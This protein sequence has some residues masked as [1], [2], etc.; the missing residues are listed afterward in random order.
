MELLD[1]SC[2]DIGTQGAQALVAALASSNLKTL[3][4]GPKATRLD[5]RDTA[6]LATESEPEEELRVGRS[7]DLSKQGLRDAELI[8]VAWWLSL[9]CYAGG[10]RL[11]LS[12]NSITGSVVSSKDPCLYMCICLACVIVYVCWCVCA[13]VSFRVS[14]CTL[15]RRIPLTYI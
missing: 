7:V 5:L 1:I 4:F 10:S 13:Y 11:D 14:G 15:P 3:L 9:P 12:G 2:N 8:I 6:R